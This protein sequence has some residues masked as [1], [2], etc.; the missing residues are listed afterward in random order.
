MCES[1]IQ[2]VI[3]THSADFIDAEFLEGLV[4]VY[5]VGNTTKAKQLTR[6]EL[7]SFCIEL[8]GE[9][10]NG[11]TGEFPSFCYPLEDVQTMF[12]ELSLIRSAF[13]AGGFLFNYRDAGTR[14]FFACAR[15]LASAL[16]LIISSWFAAL[17]QG[18]NVQLAQSGFWL[19][20]TRRPW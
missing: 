18:C 12:F 13:P 1:G 14:F 3:S 17:H 19:W 10:K 4:R 11:H 2:V 9:K 20:H 6:D 5:K 16:G 8:R 15:F 7:C